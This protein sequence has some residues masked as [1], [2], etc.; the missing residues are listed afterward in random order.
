[1]GGMFSLPET[2]IAPEPARVLRRADLGREETTSGLVAEM[3]RLF[4]DA[5][6][7]DEP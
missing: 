4:V 1:M 5:G 2:A 6:A 3:R 7:V